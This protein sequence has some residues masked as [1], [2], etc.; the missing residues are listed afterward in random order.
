MQYMG[1]NTS[2]ISTTL[3]LKNLKTRNHFSQ[4]LV[5]SG[6]FIVN[7]RGLETPRGTEQGYAGVGVRV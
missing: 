2:I 5:L 7:D 4:D 6:S 3:L 1:V